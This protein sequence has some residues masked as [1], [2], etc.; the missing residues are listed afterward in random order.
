MSNLEVTCP[1]GHSYEPDYPGSE[2]CP[3]CAAARNYVAKATRPI[4]NDDGKIPHPR[5]SVNVPQS[6]TN[7]TVPIYED[8]NEPV[9]GWLVAIEGPML[10]QDFRLRPEMNL[11]GRDPSNN[12]ALTGDATISAR[13]GYISF[14]PR[15]R[16]FMVGPGQGS[17]LLYRNG[18]E[19]LI[20]VALAAYDEL[21]MGKS[22]FVFIPFC[23][24][25]FSWDNSAQ[26]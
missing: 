24:E 8:M 1:Q 5:D 21:E 16:R 15:K 6:A 18:D 13:Q 26:R 23:G 10:G 12:I 4:Y 14:D 20:P 3:M 2:N 9:V 11:L 7:K 22:K 19:V 25:R 17:R